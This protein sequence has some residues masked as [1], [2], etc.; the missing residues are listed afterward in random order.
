MLAVKMSAATKPVL[1]LIFC[2]YIASA[3]TWFCCIAGDNNGSGGGRGNNA[4]GGNGGNNN[5]NNANGGN[6]NKG[7]NNGNGGNA[8]GNNGNGGMGGNAGGGEFLTMNV[9]DHWSLSPE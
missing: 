2:K 9:I 8:Q 5:G 7:N 4:S 3:S 1:N 6:D